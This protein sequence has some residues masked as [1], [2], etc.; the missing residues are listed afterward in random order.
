[1]AGGLITTLLLDEAYVVGV[2]G[3]DRKTL[4]EGRYNVRLQQEILEEHILVQEWFKKGYEFLRDK[5]VEGIEALKDKA[6]EVPNAIKQYGSDLKGVVAALTAMVRDPEELSAYA[7]GIFAN[8]RRWPRSI[9]KALAKIQKWMEDHEMPTFAKGIGKIIDAIKALF[10]AATSAK[11]WKA[12]VSMLS[13]GLAVKYI[14][15]E[16]GVL[17]KARKVRNVL[18]DPK[19]LIPDL[20]DAIGER[21]EIDDI[22]DFFAGKITAVVED[23]ELFKKI[24]KFL[25][26]KLG[27]LEEIKDKFINFGKQIAGKALEQFAG[28]I[29]WIKQLVELFQSSEWVVSNLSSLLTSMKIGGNFAKAT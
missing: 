19:E 18:L 21:E 10:K 16:F 6:L 2:L 12:A 5:G 13:F 20:V 9:M 27:F 7:N 4:N 24:T 26:D 8:I 15:E 17:E 29:A 25:S 22:K 11:G 23:S 14:E 28:P 1:M 3:F